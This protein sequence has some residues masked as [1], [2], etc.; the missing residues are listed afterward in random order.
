MPRAMPIR[1]HV[2]A[3]CVMFLAWLPLALRAQQADFTGE[4]QTFWRTGSATL[5][6]TQEGDAVTGSYEP[7]DGTVTGTV[8]G[9]V[10]RGSW[11]QPGASGTMVF[12]LSEDGRVLT[13][14]FGN[15]EY[16]NGFRSV[17]D[18]GVGD[19][20]MMNATPRET[21]RTLLIAMNAAVYSDNARALRRID[22]LLTYAGNPAS[23]GERARR[24]TLMF[25]ILD[26]S[27][28]RIMDIPAGPEEPEDRTVLVEIGPAAV[29]DKT[30][31]EFR[32][33]PF[34]GWRIVLPEA[35]TLAAER[36]RLLAAMGHESMGDL[37]LA[38]ANAPR[39]VMREFIQGTGAWQEGGRDRALA[40]MDLSEVPEHRHQLEGPIYADFLQRI[41]DRIGYVIWQEI[42]DDP[43][44]SVPYTYFQHPVGNI[45]IAR[46]VQAG[47]GP[48]GAAVPGAWL[49]S[50]ATLASAPALYEAMQEL[51]LIP[52]LQDPQPLS[53]FFQLRESVRQAAPGLMAG[54]GYLELWQWLGL[55][56]AL[57]GGA[58]T[59]WLVRAALRAIAQSTER[60][61]A[62]SQLAL[63]TGLLAA[64]AILHYAVTWLGV[65][66]VGLPVVSSLAGAFLIFALA[67]FAYR[68]AGVIGS[69]FLANARRTTSYMD[70]IAATLGTGLVKLLIVVGAIIAL[71]DVIGLPYE[72]VLTGLGVGGVAVA[73]AARDTVSNIMGGGLLMADRPFQRGDM[74]ELDGTLATVE[75]VGLRSTKLRSLDDALLYVPNAQL[76]DR[77]IANWGRRRRRKLALTVG[78]TYDTPREKLDS[79]VRR[80]REVLLSQPSVDREDVYV[81]L[82]EFGASSID[83]S[84]LCHFRVP[85]YAE[86]IEAQ[87]KLI[88]DIIALAE[89]VGVEF[90]FPTRT[91]QLSGSLRSDLPALSESDRPDADT[92][93]SVAA[94]GG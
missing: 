61:D 31:L 5:S 69:W 22:R 54:W 83:I 29:P 59:A 66:Q 76:S 36:D 67:F 55:A 11:E 45:T 58:L 1:I 48:D 3:I 81:G 79:F 70:E 33:D 84:V 90:A 63:P 38:R 85:G 56:A 4:W 16:W 27:T 28:L 51:P 87:H 91:V 71:A 94:R 15:G 68:L 25:D 62:L 93:P 10:L 39:A 37:E 46:A 78:L 20:A 82:K 6:L 53:P 49:L 86:Q 12:A 40:V 75:E 26:M 60:L 52:G 72:G 13:G 2:L 92:G 47:E 42:P 77:A 73:F 35:E 74:I 44:R 32:R 89:D 21:L 80:L 50:P 65:T 30:Q 18:G 43:D 41:I 8:E 88:M 17:E 57:V 34:G 23:A 24:R 19:M 7:Y 9:R 64:A 14:R